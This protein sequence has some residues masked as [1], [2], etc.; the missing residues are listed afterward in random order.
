MARA[1]AVIPRID[2]QGAA[3]RHPGRPGPVVDPQF[4]PRRPRVEAQHQVAAVEVEVRRLGGRRLEVLPPGLRQ[5]E[6]HSHGTDGTDGPEDFVV[7]EAL[8]VIRPR[9]GT[10][11]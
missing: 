4:Q 6:R 5:V 3:G 9:I 7:G 2:L 8:G 1:T 11:S 10:Y